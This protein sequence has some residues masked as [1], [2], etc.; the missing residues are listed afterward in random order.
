MPDHDRR[1]ENAERDTAV[2]A[3]VA[4]HC[5]RVVLG[6]FVA[7]AEPARSRQVLVGDADGTA[8]DVGGGDVV[9]DRDAD[10][11]GGLENPLGPADVVAHDLAHR[12]L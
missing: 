10:V 8:G 7:V 3:V 12:L 11:E 6:L 5:L 2:A 9:E 4:H 1:A